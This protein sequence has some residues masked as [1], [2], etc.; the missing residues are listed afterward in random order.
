MSGRAHPAPGGV[1]G[2][3]PALYPCTVVH[4]RTSPLR[5]AF[6]HR[7]YLWLV[8]PDAL[9]VLP[10]WARP[11]AGFDARDH[12][13]GSAPT[14][15]AG[16]DRFLAANGVDPSGLRVLMLT[17]A[18]V[19]GHVFNPVTLYWCRDA[20]GAP[21]CVVAEVHNTYGGRHCYLLRPDG[22]QVAEADKEFYV[23]PF[24][25]VDGRYRM[26]LPEPDGRLDVAVR[27]ERGGGR[28]FSATVR[29]VRRPGTAGQLLRLAVR[30][31]LATAWVSAHIRLRG[32]AL[33][34]RGLKV[35]PRPDRP[36]TGAATGTEFEK[37]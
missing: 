24:F 2:P 33:F 11:L 20:A 29:G 1:P 7:T 27:L 14:V 10:R 15:R 19:L 17:A 34:L 6:R 35:F 16:L 28:P 21:V 8:D 4:V 30:R 32:T 26:R 25:P 12:F 31:P 36:G 18:R 37:V 3:A 9:P 22:R 5:D 23:S 13:D